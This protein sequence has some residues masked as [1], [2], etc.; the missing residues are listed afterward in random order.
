MRFSSRSL[1]IAGLLA[2]L[3]V[4]HAQE[5]DVGEDAAAPPPVEAEASGEAGHGSLE[6]NFGYYANDDNG[7]GN[8]FLDE[9]ETVIEPV[10]VVNYNVTDWLAVHVGVSIDTVTSASIE[11]LSQTP[12]QSGASKDTYVGVDG[13]VVV[14]PTDALS[15]GVRGSHSDEYDYSSNGFG[16]DLSLDL[17]DSNTTISLSGNV[18]LDT[19]RTIRWDGTETGDEDRT[20]FTISPGLYQILSS[21]V[22]MT[23]GY[24]FTL[25]DGFLETAFNSVVLEDP[26]DPP[27]PNLD[28]NA[29]GV[30][31]TEELPD[32]RMRHALYGRVRK[33][34]DTG[35]AVE[36]G[37]RLY[38]D[39]WGVTSESLE[40]RL[41]QWVVPEVF[42]VR[43]RYRFY[44]QSAADDYSEHFFVAP[45][46]RGPYGVGGGPDRT[47]DADL[48]DF[49]SHTV[50]LKLDWTVFKDAEALGLDRLGLS[51]HVGLDYV[52]RSDG[53]DQL[54]LYGGLKV[55]F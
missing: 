51:V 27:N 29:R 11:R 7:D 46:N 24:S 2:T 31:V 21:T 36:L 44:N 47:Q 32:T 40:L 5:A 15:I 3:G 20:S 33:Y 38:T 9:E 35:T 54:L 26:S 52:L 23:L 13:G 37:T 45:G 41:Y 10:I 48:G 19:V 39:S 49:T 12:D 1:V 28:N 22:H 53:I 4:A 17:N 55:D 43:V 50:G 42:R 8:P 25:Q 16:V 6:V 18:F 30:E 14:R 34:F